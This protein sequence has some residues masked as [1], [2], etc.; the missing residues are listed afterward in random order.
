MT[1]AFIDGAQTSALLN[2]EHERAFCWLDPTRAE[3]AF[4]RRTGISFAKNHSAGGC[5]TPLVPGQNAANRR[6]DTRVLAERPW[7]ATRMANRFTLRH[8]KPSLRCWRDTAWTG[9]TCQRYTQSLWHFHRPVLPARPPHCH[10]VMR[11]HLR[12]SAV[13]GGSS[14]K[15]LN[16]R[17]FLGIPENRC[18]AKRHRSCRGCRASHRRGCP[19][20][21]IQRAANPAT[22][23]NSTTHTP[24]SA[25]LTK[26]SPYAVNPVCVSPRLPFSPS[27][28]SCQSCPHSFPIDKQGVLCHNLPRI[29]NRVK[30]HVRGFGY[31]TGSTR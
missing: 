26:P 1:P 3:R 7:K 16:G 11:S 17:P 8:S 31:L 12:K 2:R 18:T 28:P 13:P 9:T 5:A 19:R 23:T 24:P 22:P 27:S 29:V 30:T 21:Y 10:P 14:P 15:L 25:A 6:Q 4:L 20:L